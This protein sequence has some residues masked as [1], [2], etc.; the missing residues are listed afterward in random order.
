MD[1]Q[2][3]S[4]WIANLGRMTIGLLGAA[5]MALS[6][7]VLTFVGV[8]LSAVGLQFWGPLLWAMASSATIF[9]VVG[10]VLAWRGAALSEESRSS[11]RRRNL[12]QDVLDWAES[13]GGEV[14]VPEVALRSRY[15]VEEV[16]DQ[17]NAF[18]DEGVAEPGVSESG[19]DVYIFP[20]FRDPDD[21]RTAT[22]PL[23]DDLEVE[24]SGLGEASSDAE[25]AEHEVEREK[26]RVVR[27]DD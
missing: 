10:M 16:R 2:R 1:L 13:L 27:S 11:H 20:E 19:R 15:T 21:R 6:T 12:Q 4:D 17:L 5:L 7:F 22:A 8:E 26:E 25:F 9:L 18:V 14:T 23:E 24:L 3:I